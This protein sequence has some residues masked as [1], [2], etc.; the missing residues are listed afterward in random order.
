MRIA[1]EALT[2]D[3]V[4]LQPAYSE[5][6][7]REVSLATRLT[8]S[9]RLN[10]PLLS[11]AID[12]VTEARLAKTLAQEGGKGIIHKNLSPAEQAR[13]LF[14]A[15]GADSSLGVFEPAV[16]AASF[17]K[18]SGGRAAGGEDLTLCLFPFG[19]GGPQQR[20]D[21]GLCICHK[22]NQVEA[23]AIRQAN[24]HNRDGWAVH[25]EVAFSGGKAIGAPQAGTGPQ[26]HQPGGL[27]RVAAILYNQYSQSQKR[28]FR[29]GLWA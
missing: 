16:A 12:S 8:R 19:A 25:V 22:F 11:A 9:I 23:R 15:L 29:R 24:V 1:K 14:V 18:Q 2:F 27:R 3:D 10:V 5:V 4:L 17:K 21:P 6:L 7:P 26:A 20:L 28:P 13:R